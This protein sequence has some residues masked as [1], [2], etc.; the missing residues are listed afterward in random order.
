MD[1]PTLGRRRF[2]AAAGVVAGAAAGLAPA[3]DAAPDLRTWGGVRR[4][5]EL[6]PRLDNFAAFVLAP[7]PRAVRRAIDRHRRGLDRNPIAYLHA[8]EGRLADAVRA[9]AARYLGTG[10]EQVAL[11]DSTTMGLGLL[12]GGLDLRRGDEVVTTAHDFYA[13]HEALRLRAQRGGI[14]V[15]R[16]P[17]YADPAAPR[18]D[19]IVS[20]L[21]RA[22]TPRTRAVALTWVH[23]STG[24]KL[25]IRR[26]ADALPDR[27]LLCVDGVHA[28]GVEDANVGRLGCDFLVAGCHKWLWGP[29]GTGIVWGRGDAWSRV[30][31]TIPSFDGASYGAWLAGVAPAGPRAAAVTPGGYHS[32]EHRWALA[33]A[34]RFHRAVGLARIRA[35]THALAARLKDE[36]ASVRGV[37]VVTPRSPALS[38]GIV[39]LTVDGA[40]PQQVVASLRERRI[41]ASVTPYA[42]QYVRLGASILVDEAAVRRVAPALAR[43][44]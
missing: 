41:V 4:E 19:E 40:A 14:R 16:V 23:S 26:I 22:V 2:L 36:L 21:V 10:A 24:V 17:L 6:D 3:A 18:A 12:Y 31:P 25:P 37:R 15:R 43:V 8:H 20:A 30:R 35:R 27:V 28:L 42:T 11:T 5:F 29:R 7:H 33:D 44:R 9:E 34:F 39:C 38:S 13:T 1:E 32:F